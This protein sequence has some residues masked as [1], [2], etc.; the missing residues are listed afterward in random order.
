M[1]NK[2]AALYNPYLNILGGG[3]KYSLSILKALEDEGYRPYVFWDKNL[4]KEFENKFSLR[5]SHNLT[6]LPNIFNKKTNLLKKLAATKEFD[7]FLY[8]TDGSYF[9]SGAKKNFI[10][11]MIP[12]KSLYQLS[13]ANRLKTINY[14]LI[15]HSKF[16]QKQLNR[17]KIKT[18]L[19]YFYLDEAF[20]KN[21]SQKTEKEKIILSVGR[22]FSHLHS[23]RQD[24]IIKTFKKLKQSHPAFKDF[25]LILAGGLNPED[26]N[27]FN[28]LVSAIGNDTSIILKTNLSF[29]NLFDLY[30]K[31]MF[32]WHFAGFGIDENKSPELVEHFGISPLE[33]M[34]CGCLTFCYE[35]GGPKEVIVNGKTGFLFKDEK[36]LFKDMELCLNNQKK[37][38]IIINGGKSFVRK[39]FTY[40]KFKKRVV[41]IFT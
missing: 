6:F 33:A 34:A 37:A 9:F 22:F 14:K 41:E 13:L 5:F 31:S 7:I 32:Y 19:V 26:N 21:N 28:K 10:Y 27:Y 36:T 15:T 30:K 38:Q 23:K 35:A 1:K 11:A 25:K 29:K 3:E 24:L 4:E 12:K 2:K 18:N 8:V 17:W 40:D 16:N 20:I 39:N